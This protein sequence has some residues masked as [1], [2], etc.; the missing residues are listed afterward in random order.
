[1]PTT[2]PKKFSIPREVQA[3]LAG[4]AND[5]RHLSNRVERLVKTIAKGLPFLA[6]DEHIPERG[7]VRITGRVKGDEEL[8]GKNGVALA[9]GPDA[10]GEWSYTVLIDTINETYI[11]PESA[12][13]FAGWTVPEQA[14]YAGKPIRVRV[15]KA[16]RGTVVGHRSKKK[17]AK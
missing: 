10:V 9:G 5:A 15:D 3:Q 7:R 11:L 16:G 8:K 12:L 17:A 2:A 14:L 4:V 13:S 6:D 1:M